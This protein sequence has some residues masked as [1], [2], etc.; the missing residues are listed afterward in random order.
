MGKYI[1]NGTPDREAVLLKIYERQ[2]SAVLTKAKICE[3][4]FLEYPNHKT[5]VCILSR[6][7]N[8]DVVVVYA[9]GGLV[10]HH[11]YKTENGT[12]SDS[13][14][15]GTSMNRQ[16]TWEWL[17]LW[18][19][20]NVAIAILDVPD[21]FNAHGYPWVSSFYRLSKDRVRESK[22]C[23]ELVKQRFPEASVNWFGLSYGAL[24]SAM[25]SLEHTDLK[26]IISASGTWYERPDIDLH[27][28]G[29]RLTWYDV[30]K[31]TK[32]VLIVMHEKEVHNYVK[33]QMSKTES[34][35]VTN[36][37][38]EEDGHFFRQRQVEVITAMC[39]W[40]RDKPIPKIIP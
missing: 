17:D 14:G 13:T 1:M 36:D 28:Q 23:I 26:K 21:Y 35:T 37:V 20:Q 32:P 18:L 7:E 8:P 19:D 22:Q 2:R 16:F 3:L 38:S 27:H 33:T 15:P 29:A 25:I 40:L 5:A 30:E 6:V 4:E 34:I 12:V 31:S 9:Y 39:N 24:D 10:P 11:F